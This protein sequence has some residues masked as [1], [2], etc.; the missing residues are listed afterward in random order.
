MLTMNFTKE[1]AQIT[2]S[3]SRLAMLSDSI[4]ILLQDNHQLSVDFDL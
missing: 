1:Y 4:L 2:L 3:K